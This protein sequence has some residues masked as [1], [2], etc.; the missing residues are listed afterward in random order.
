VVPSALDRYILL[1]SD[2]ILRVVT[3]GGTHDN[4]RNATRFKYLGD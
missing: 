4:P 1:E 2:G 3:K